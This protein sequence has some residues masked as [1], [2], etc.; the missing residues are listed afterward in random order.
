MK[1]NFYSTYFSCMWYFEI[2]LLI[3]QIIHIGFC[4]NFWHSGSGSTNYNL[5]DGKFM[6]ANYHPENSAEA[7]LKLHPVA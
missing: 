3:A 6:F 2:E 1:L 5:L 4:Q 7:G